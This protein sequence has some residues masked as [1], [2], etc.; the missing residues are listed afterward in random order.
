[1][2]R[3]YLLCTLLL[4]LAPLAVQAQ[5]KRSASASSYLKRANARYAKGDIQ[6]AIADFDIAIT[7]DPLFATA[8]NNRAIAREK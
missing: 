1:M 5:E 4:A 2:P 8:Y 6:G 7:F 3:L